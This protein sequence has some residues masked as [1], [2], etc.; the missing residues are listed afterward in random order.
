[1]PID[2]SQQERDL[3]SASGRSRVLVVDDHPD[4]VMTLSMLLRLVGFEV[5]G[6]PDGYRA[7]E[8]AADFRPDAV[9]LDIG[10]PGMDGYEVIRRLR[11]D[12]ACGA[13]PIIAVTGYGDDQHKNRIRE[14]GF[15][16]HLVKPVVF[17][18]MLETFSRLGAMPGPCSGGNVEAG[19]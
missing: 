11:A 3:L 6:A 10:L 7:L 14:A 12:A 18:V 9:L 5:M 1:M 16:S 8:I 15:D 2:V 17:D 13:I 4:I 19:R